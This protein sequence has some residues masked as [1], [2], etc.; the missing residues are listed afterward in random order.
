MSAFKPTEKMEN[1][2]LIRERI[3]N[4]KTLIISLSIHSQT[5]SHELSASYSPLSTD[6]QSF[7]MK[8]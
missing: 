4:S 2:Y 3:N 1:T 5:H 8:T 7:K 6:V